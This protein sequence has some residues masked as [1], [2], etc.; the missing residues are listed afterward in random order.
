MAT[1]SSYTYQLEAFIAAVRHGV[2]YRTDAD[3]AVATMTLIDDC[4]RAIGLQPRPA[5]R[6]DPERRAMRCF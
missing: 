5:Q 6:D 2:A 4:Y 1:A 3:D